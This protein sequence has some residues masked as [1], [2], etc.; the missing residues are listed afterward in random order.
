[1]ILGWAY[2]LDW[3]GTR[4][5]FIQKWVHPDPLLLIKDGE[6]IRH[7]MK[8]EFITRD[9]LMEEIRLQGFEEIK[10]VRRAWIEGDGRFSIMPFEQKQ[11]QDSSQGNKPQP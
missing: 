4:F 5:P 8:A 6:L 10:Q 2:T 7:N 9:E 1:M 3:L 11:Q